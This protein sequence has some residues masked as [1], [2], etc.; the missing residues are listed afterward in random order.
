MRRY[1]NPVLLIKHADKNFNQGKIRNGGETTMS[2]M[3]GLTKTT[4]SGLEYEIIKKD[5][6][7]KHGAQLYL[8]KFTNT[9]TEMRVLKASIKSGTIKDRFHPSVYDVGCLGN[10]KKVGNERVYSL[11]NNM[12]CRCYHN[13]KNN[14]DYMSYGG[15][16]VRV[17]ERWKIFSN[18]LSDL[19]N[20]EGYDEPLFAQGKIHLDKDKKQSNTPPSQKIYSLETCCFISKED[21]QVMRN[22]SRYRKKFMAISP[23]GQRIYVDGLVDFSKENNLD[24]STI[25]RCLRGEYKQH[26]GWTFEVV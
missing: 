18:F 11:W 22:T 21:N 10:A 16:G 9:G 4:K 13:H 5:G 25:T 19:E 24:A 3:L 15:I 23:D 1:A 2:E 12:L 17:C 8:I 26:K 14:K 7:N 6:R 20:I